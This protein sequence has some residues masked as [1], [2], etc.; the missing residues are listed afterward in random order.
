M[1]RTIEIENTKLRCHFTG[2]LERCHVMSNEWKECKGSIATN[3]YL[4]MTINKKNYRL[5]RIMG[6]AFGL[7]ELN[8]S[9]DID[10][11]DRDRHNNCIF[12]LRPATRQQNMMN[13]DAKGYTWDIGMHKWR[14]YITVNGVVKILG[15]FDTKEKAHDAY[16]KEKKILHSP[17]LLIKN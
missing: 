2:K 1:I 12:N 4:Q 16:L 15:Y 10:H 7:L 14:A 5:H 13:K 11:K 9:L 3:G 17:F 8:S 6:Y